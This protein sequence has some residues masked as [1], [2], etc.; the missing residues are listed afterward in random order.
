M[1]NKTEEK[2]TVAYQAYQTFTLATTLSAQ[3]DSKV[4]KFKDIWEESE[5]KLK[6]LSQMYG[7]AIHVDNQI[8][9]GISNNRKKFVNDIKQ[10]IKRG[11]ITITTPIGQVLKFSSKRKVAYFGKP[12]GRAKSSAGNGAGNQGKGKDNQGNGAGNQ[13]KGKGKSS[14]VKNLEEKIHALKIALKAQQ[15]KHEAEKKSLKNSW[16]TPRSIF[17]NIIQRKNP[18]L[19]RDVS[20]LLGN[21]VSLQDRNIAADKAA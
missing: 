15:E 8:N 12:D 1:K 3:A 18:T 5:D 17:D 11:D 2:T 14:E 4:K 9:G 19:I 10:W 21:Y 7:Y 6:L 13:G 16:L 20:V